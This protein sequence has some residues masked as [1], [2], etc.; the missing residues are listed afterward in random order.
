MA[1]DFWERARS[2]VNAVKDIAWLAES[3]AEGE[4]NQLVKNA[5]DYTY[6]WGYHTNLMNFVKWMNVD[7][8]RRCSYDLIYNA[9][10][11]AHNG[12]SRMVYLSNHDI[13]QENGTEDRIFGSNVAP[14]TVLQFTVYG[15]PLIYNGQ[16]I[17]YSSG[18]ISIGKKTPIDWSDP[19]NER[20]ALIRKLAWLKHTEPALNTSS[21]SAD[22]IN[23]TSTDNNVYVYERRRGSE[24]VVVMLNFGDNATTFTVTSQLPAATFN[25]TFT[26]AT[27]D[28]TTECTFSLPAKGYAVYTKG[29]GSGE[30]IPPV[31]PETYT[32]TFRRPSSWTNTPNV[33][34]YY[35]TGSGSDVDL[36]SNQPM[37]SVAGTTDLFEYPFTNA[38]NGYNVMFNNGGWGNGQSANSFYE[39]QAGNYTYTLDSGLNV[40]RDSGQGTDPD[41]VDPTEKRYVYISNQTGWDNLH[42]Y[43]WTTN[44]PEIFGSWPGIASSG[45]KVINDVEYLCFE[46]PESAWEQTYNLIINNG[47]KDGEQGK[48]QLTDQVV[49]LTSNI[50]IVAT[51]SGTTVDIASIVDDIP[52]APAEFYNLQGQRIQN[53]SNGI[54]IRRRGAKVDK[55]IIR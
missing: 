29:E 34:V 20:T 28:F 9:D 6:A 24:S 52:E 14:L 5:F 16:E 48:Q 1:L 50:F 3:G 53:P 21:E 31:E 11:V 43:A 42:L 18:Q 23:H 12:K 25:D 22:L 49:A 37:T 39:P 30:I 44:G 45:T 54:Y 46:I 51:L 47:K 26:G 33:H 40:V 15:M 55:I 8:L 4:H 32:I 27:A 2:E 36:I 17:G 19:D 41:P 38:R 7:D 10:G 13:V 35:S